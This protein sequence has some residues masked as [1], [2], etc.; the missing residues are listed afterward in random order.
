MPIDF[1]PSDI[2]LAAIPLVDTMGKAEAELAAAL[3]LIGLQHSGD[4]WRALPAR[5]MGL[6][7]QPLVD[8]PPVKYWSNPFVHPDFGELVKRGFAEFIE[9]DG[10]ARGALRFTAKGIEAVRR[11]VQPSESSIREGS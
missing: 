4:E 7:L 1:K 6:A 2:V 11:R 3:L 10:N 8:K 5:E 9:H